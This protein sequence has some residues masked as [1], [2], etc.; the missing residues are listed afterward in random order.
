MLIEF[1]TQNFRSLRER[2]RISMSA[3]SAKEHR[4]KNCFDSGI[5]GLPQLLKSAVVYGPNAAGKT[6]LLRAMHF[7]QVMVLTSANS[8]Q[9]G[10]TINVKPFELVRKSRGAPSEFEVNFVEDGVRF[11]YGF[12]LNKT[13]VVEE[14][15]IAYPVGRPQLWFERSVVGKSEDTTWNFGSKFKG[16]HKLWR[17]ATRPN[18]LFLST[19]IQLNNEQ[20]RPIFN[21]FQKRLV[22]VIPGVGVTLNPTLTYAL[23]ANPSGKS[24]VMSFLNAAN[25]G[26]DDLSVETQSVGAQNMAHS[27]KTLNGLMMM[28]ASGLGVASVKAMH[29]TSDRAESISLD[30]TDESDGTQKLIASAG[31]WLKI[32][33]EGQI[34][35]IDELNNSL[36]PLIVR[37]LV[38]LFHKL[39]SN[40]LNAQIIFSSHDTSILDKDIFR[41]DQVWFVEKDKSQGSV[42]Y[43]LSEFSPR[44]EEAFER[45]YLK[46]RYGA[47]PNIREL[48]S[49]G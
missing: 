14:W 39:D 33:S 5:E 42:L 43:A 8:L 4:S 22:V 15:L 23:L 27:P 29:K 9:Q 13:R 47:L 26:I 32:L 19:A 30:I 44:P 10:Q 21:W 31:A 48:A 18:A 3:S 7:M 24:S 49:R 41:R 35:F 45:N 25:V 46:G 40:K 12:A 28:G 11:Q 20:L 37:F 34:L 17:D 2:Q 36:H 16:P 6:N 1:S 38:E